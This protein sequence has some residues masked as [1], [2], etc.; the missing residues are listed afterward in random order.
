MKWHALRLALLALLPLTWPTV[1]LAIEAQPKYSCKPGEFIIS[2]LP[3]RGI[4]RKA[5]ESLSAASSAPLAIADN[6]YNAA[7]V[8]IEKPKGFRAK[9][10][11]LCAK[12]RQHQRA[13]RRALREQGKHP[14]VRT[15]DCNC[16]ALVSVVRTPN[17][18]LSQMQWAISQASDIDSNLNLAWDRWVGDNNYPVVAV[19]DTGIDYNHPDLAENMWVNPGE[20]AG[21]GIDDDRN[22]Y[23]DDVHGANLIS[24]TGN[25]MDDNGHGTH[26]AGTIGAVG[27]NGRG[28]AG[29]AW[30]VKLIGAKFLNRAGGGELFDAVKAI[31]YITDL[32]QR[33]IPIVASNNSWGG[34][35]YL[36]AMYDAIARSEAAGVL[37]IAAA[38]NSSLNNDQVANYPSNYNNQ[39]IIAVAS[40]E[41]TGNL[42]SFSNYGRTTVDIA[43][44]GGSIA[45]TYTNNEYRY[46]SGTSMAAPHVA[47]A[48]ALLKGFAPG[49]SWSEIKD[50]LLR[51]AR[52]LPNLRRIV[53]TGAMLDVAAILNE[54]ANSGVNGP[55]PSPTPT[56]APTATPTPRPTA[57]PIPTATPTP[58][59]L[60]GRFNLSGRIVGENG[61]GIQ[62]AKLT[63]RVGS[64]VITQFTGGSGEYSFADI[65]G[66]VSFSLTIEK[67]GLM[68]TVHSSTLLRDTDLNL[69]TSWKRYS[70]AARVVSSD[71]AP[72]AGVTINAGPLGTIVTNNAGMAEFR[73]D[74]G[75][76][77]TISAS[78]PEHSFG[79]D[80]RKGAL[81][82]DTVRLFVGRTIDP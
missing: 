8:S 21:N 58:L 32:R 12:L 66:P 55:I 20:I 22:G 27:N 3:S 82:G 76:P 51:T 11:D 23:V 60:P 47:G 13:T 19:V 44:P 43:A 17:D 29:V 38:G 34:G 74:Y 14:L 67:G 72:M 35:P 52:P 73:A 50:I 26:V 24:N 39:S 7:L 78:S 45:S 54:A 42:S 33:G 71:G 53:V 69:T 16:N 46:L 49:L 56:A 4:Q 80:T 36:P 65:F 40:I 68:T 61:Q 15:V 9:V 41:S 59:P 30:R 6:T 28:V 18:P 5:L 25:P 48:V 31:N 57:T 2:R 63:L 81:V 37:F 75:T 79:E 77:Y 70:L 10:E 1:S 64:T 62:N